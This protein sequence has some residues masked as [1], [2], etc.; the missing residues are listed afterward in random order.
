[1][2]D[3]AKRAE[4]VTQESSQNRKLTAHRFFFGY[5]YDLLVHTSLYRQWQSLLRTV[6]RFRAVAFTLRVLTFVLTVVETGALVILSTA[7]FLVILPLATALTLGL[8][9]TALLE[10]KRTNRYFSKELTG[11]HVYVLFLSEESSLFFW[12]NAKS[13]AQDE[14]SAVIVVSPYWISAKGL[15]K[16]PFYCTAR[17][18]YPNLYLIRRYYFFRLRKQVLGGLHVAYV[19]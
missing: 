17:Q 13:L 8:L 12:Q 2:N 18:E 16:A 11:K 19:Y 10:S 4:H 7:V 15:R 9:L 1:M 6:R 5:A 14:Q 3:H